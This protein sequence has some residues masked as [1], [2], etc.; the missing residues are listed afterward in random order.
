M[1]KT[2]V[3][4]SHSNSLDILCGLT[5]IVSYLGGM[6]KKQTKE[7]SAPGAPPPVPPLVPSPEQLE[8]NI[9]Q[10]LAKAV[11]FLNWIRATK[12]ALALL[13][14]FAHGQIVNSVNA[15]QAKKDERS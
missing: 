4:A 11:A 1:P 8:K 3:S 15:D 13:A 2:P 9:E 7:A 6:S 12:P 14:E 5:P 10:D